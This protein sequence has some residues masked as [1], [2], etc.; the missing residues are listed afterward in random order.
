MAGREER[1]PGARGMGMTV[2]WHY[3]CK[4]DRPPLAV[5]E[6]WQQLGHL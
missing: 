3:G 5:C 4:L 6:L 2:D 1:D